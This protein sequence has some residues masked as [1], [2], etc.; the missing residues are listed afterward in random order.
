MLKQLCMFEVFSEQGIIC[1]KGSASIKQTCVP[2]VT[3]LH[4]GIQGIQPTLWYVFDERDNLLHSIRSDVND[5]FVSSLYVISKC[6]HTYVYHIL[7]TYI[8]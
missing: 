5:V 3:P 4:D 7:D 8:F 1:N 6:I 2:M